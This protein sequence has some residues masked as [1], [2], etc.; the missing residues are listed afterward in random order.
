VFREV[1]WIMY[2]RCHWPLSSDSSA[3]PGSKPHEA[4]FSATTRIASAC[5]SRNRMPGF[6]IARAASAASSTASYTCRWMSLKRP[7][8]GSVRVMSAV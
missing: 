1:P 8:T 3:V 5:T 2:R 7:F 4:V 6:T